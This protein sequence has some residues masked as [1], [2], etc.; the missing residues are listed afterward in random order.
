MHRGQKEYVR[1]TY[2]WL[3]NDDFSLRI[4]KKDANGMFMQTFRTLK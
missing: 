3:K 2:Q 4:G 1:Q